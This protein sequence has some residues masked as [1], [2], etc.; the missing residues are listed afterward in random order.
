MHVKPI[1]IIPFLIHIARIKSDVST[2]L[3][4]VLFSTFSL[5]FSSNKIDTSRSISMTFTIQWR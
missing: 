2:T 5:S 1:L 3:H 4:F